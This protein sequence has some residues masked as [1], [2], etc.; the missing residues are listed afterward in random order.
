MRHWGSLALCTVSSGKAECS[1]AANWELECGAI[2]AC[3]DLPVSQSEGKW[4]CRG[5]GN[6]GG[7]GCKEIK[8]VNLRWPCN[9]DAR[10]SWIKD[11]R[12]SRMQGV[13][14][15]KEIK[16]VNL[17]WPCKVEAENVVVVR[18]KWVA[19]WGTWVMRALMD[20]INIITSLPPPQAHLIWTA[21]WWGWFHTH[22]KTILE[23]YKHVTQ[24]Y[25]L[26]SKSCP[27]QKTFDIFPTCCASFEPVC[28]WFIFLIRNNQQHCEEPVL[29][30][31]QSACCRSSDP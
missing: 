29:V 26:A 22:W 16:G 2:K 7:G 24:W 17:R 20:F 6:G 11:A 31:W 5:W 14:G 23:C 10:R 27:G 8:G 15:C 18:L 30:L 28:V 12:R 3:K 9:E 25:F 21:S 19:R 1:S 4:V 13:K